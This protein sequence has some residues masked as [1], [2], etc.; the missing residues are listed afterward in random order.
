M[1]FELLT[2]QRPFDGEH[3]GSIVTRISRGEYDE[4]ALLRSPH[5][6]AL[7]LLASREALLHP[8]P[9]QRMRLEGLVERV[10]ALST[11]VADPSQQA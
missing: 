6:P 4:S 7:Q 10:G 1:L 11:T 8:E 9:E 2:L 3:L 5:P